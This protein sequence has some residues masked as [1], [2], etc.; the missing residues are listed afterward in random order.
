M[1]MLNVIDTNFGAGTDGINIREHLSGNMFFLVGE[2]PVDVSAE[3]Y[4]SARYLAISVDG[5]PFD[6]SL[7]GSAFALAEIDGVRR[8]SLTSVRIKD[9]NTI[10]IDKVPAYDSI[11]AYKVFLSGV[12]IP[13]NT[14]SWTE[15]PVAVP[16]ALEYIS[17]SLV[18]TECFRVGGDGWDML[19][20]DAAKLVWDDDRVVVKLEG[21]E[22]LSADFVPVIYTESV[23]GAMGSKYYPASLSD[24]VLTIER[25]GAAG[26]PEGTGRKFFRVFIIG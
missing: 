22:G 25:G 20:L 14:A 3:G 23:T 6:R 10:R 17:G 15:T 13:G 2:I 8:V 7:V 12:L 11:E 21:A 4:A 26:E 24:G 18:D 19:V 1:I 16:V 5:L 9:C